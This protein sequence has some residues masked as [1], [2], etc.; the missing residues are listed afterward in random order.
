MVS[1]RTTHPMTV[2]MKSYRTLYDVI[3]GNA[4][5]QY[6]GKNNPKM[7]DKLKNGP[8]SALFRDLAEKALKDE[9][10]RQ[11]WQYMQT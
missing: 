7:G 4:E 1:W 10:L 8:I 11:M 3:K 5:T 9:Q 2:D 6:K